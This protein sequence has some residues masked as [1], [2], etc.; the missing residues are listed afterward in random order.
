[1]LFAGLYK[2]TK[3]NIT[4]THTEYWDVDRTYD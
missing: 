2:Y 4:Q 3:R 1:M